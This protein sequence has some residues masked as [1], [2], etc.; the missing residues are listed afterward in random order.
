MTLA[1]GF[2]ICPLLSWRSDF[3]FLVWE[4]LSWTDA[5]SNAL[6]VYVDYHVFL[7]LS[8]WPVILIN[9][10]MLPAL[11]FCW[12]FFNA[13]ISQIS[14]VLKTSSWVFFVA[15]LDY[16]VYQVYNLSIWWSVVCMCVFGWE[17][18]R[19]E[20]KGEGSLES[21]EGKRVYDWH[22]RTPGD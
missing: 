4:L 19:E 2:C 5:F 21:G 11:H 10:Q 22:F 17:R 7:S 15:K 3:L 16:R 12:S 9:S 18:W 6:F 20:E 14:L 1:V 13:L 8:V